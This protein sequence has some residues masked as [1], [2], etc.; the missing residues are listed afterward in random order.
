[1]TGIQVHE[2]HSEPVWGTGKVVEGGTGRLIPVSFTQSA[3]DETRGGHLFDP[4]VF[5]MGG[6]NGNHGQDQIT[7]TQSFQATVCD[8]LRGGAPP[9]PLPDSAQDTDVVTVTFTVSAVAKP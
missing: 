8:L 9:A 4:M 1:M 6:G 2:S 3:N 5:A 7:C